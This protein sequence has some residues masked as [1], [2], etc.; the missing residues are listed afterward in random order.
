MNSPE[1]KQ[2]IRENASLFWWIKEDE[3]ENISL[4]LLVEAILNYGNLEDIKRLFELIGIEKVA[5]I[6]NRQTSGFRTNYYPE[7][8]NYFKLF[9]KKYAYTN[10]Y[11]R[12]N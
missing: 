4:N 8:L 2:F 1:I 12:T 7:T 5:D 9:F 3:K 11:R 10:T 6:F